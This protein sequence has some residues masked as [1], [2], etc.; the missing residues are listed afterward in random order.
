MRQVK[1]VSGVSERTWRLPLSVFMPAMRVTASLFI[2]RFPVRPAC[3][4]FPKYLQFSQRLWLCQIAPFTGGA[5]D[6]ERLCVDV[7]WDRR[8]VI[9]VKG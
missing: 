2:V 7:E 5:G 4:R 1:R 6:S 9:L 3:V 8:M